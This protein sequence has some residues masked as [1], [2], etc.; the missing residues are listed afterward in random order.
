MLVLGLVWGYRFRRED[1]GCSVF[2]VPSCEGIHD[3]CVISL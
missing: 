3:V 2:L 1:Q